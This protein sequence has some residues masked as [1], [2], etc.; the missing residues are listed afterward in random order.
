VAPLD[1][2]TAVACC[3]DAGIDPTARPETLSVADLVRLFH[4]MPR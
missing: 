4:Q 1:R 3:V 2:D